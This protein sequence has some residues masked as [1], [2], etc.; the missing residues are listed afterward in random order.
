MFLFEL[1]LVGWLISI[2]IWCVMHL[3]DCFY[4]VFDGYGYV[5]GNYGTY[6][7]PKTKQL[8][9]MAFVGGW[10]FFPYFIYLAYKYFSTKDKEKEGK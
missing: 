5:S 6:W 10:M 3:S 8:C 4:K 9:A 2:S 7:K 1:L